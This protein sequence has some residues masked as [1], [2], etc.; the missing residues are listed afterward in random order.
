MVFHLAR[1]GAL[2]PRFVAAIVDGSMN[3]IGRCESRDGNCDG[4]RGEK[5]TVLPRPNSAVQQLFDSQQ[6]GHAPCLCDTPLGTVRPIA[7]EYL[8]DTAEATVFGD[9]GQ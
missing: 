5:T 6:F 8:R 3:M 9:V 2:V 4:N 7:V 1:C